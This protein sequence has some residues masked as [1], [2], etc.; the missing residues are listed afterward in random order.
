MSQPVPC[1][2]PRAVLEDLLSVVTAYHA[3][4][5][6]RWPS[7]AR[8]DLEALKHTLEVAIRDADPSPQHTTPLN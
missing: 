2:F 5:R 4:S 1:R 6:Q 8:P 3:L 7:R